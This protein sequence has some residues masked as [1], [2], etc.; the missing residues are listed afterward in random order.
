[1]ISAYIFAGPTLPH[2]RIEKKF[3]CKLSDSNDLTLKSGE[4]IRFL[5]PVAEG[6]VLKLVPLKPKIIGIVD[7]YFENVPAVWHKEILYAMSQ[8][9]HVMGAAS[10]GALRAA[11]LQAFG[12][13]GVGASF[14]AFRDGVLEDDDEVTVAHGPEQLGFPQISEAMVNIRRTLNDACLQNIL[15]A[16]NHELLLSLAKRLHYKQR[17]YGKIITQAAE[18]GVGP[19]TLQKLQ[20]WLEEN[21]QDQKL[22][23]ALDLI[24]IIMKKIEGQ[25]GLK[26]VI[27]NFENTAIWNRSRSVSTESAI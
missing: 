7:G 12:M 18:F 19:S 8:G 23:D 17:N 16:S 11:E 2:F 20:H 10:M 22:L 26:K 24:D 9:I 5:P 13:E 4:T 21:R 6:D 25:I 27:Y 15:S 1:M 3:A 14:K